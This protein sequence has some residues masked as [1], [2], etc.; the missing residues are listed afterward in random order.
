MKKLVILLIGLFFLG[1]CAA[2]V[3]ED[4]EAIRESGKNSFIT[5]EGST[6]QSA[7]AVAEGLAV[8][9]SIQHEGEI[10][11][12]SEREGTV[13]KIIDGKVERQAVSLEKELSSVSEAGLL[14]FVLTPN[15]SDSQTA[16]AYYTY[17]D[18][19]DP[20]NRIVE[21]N[22]VNDRWQ[23]TKVLL[24]KIP[25]GTH[26][27][28][29]RLA[30]GP[31]D[32]LYATTGDA[33]E[34]EIAQDTASLGGKILRMNLD[35][36]IPEDN[37]FEDSY[38]YSYG[39]RNP[40]GLV[41]DEAGKMYASEH[42]AS[43]NDEINIIEAGKNYGWPTIEGNEEQSGMEAPLFTSGNSTTWAPSGMDYR[44]KTLYVAALRG[45]AVL[46]FDLESNNMR[47]ILTEYGRIRDIYI[48]DETMYFVTNNRDGRGSPQ[49][50]DDKFY[51][52]QLD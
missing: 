1:G 13:A 41:W 48:E 3:S 14:G 9:W 27:H 19:S 42:G 37:P 8:P 40:Q 5:E 2:T 4:E 46:E 23:E 6:N 10:F 30:I 44:D 21:L 39:H 22:L 18:N 34:P 11:Y 35:G 45:N 47:K 36:T 20:L 24:D 31:D 26:H 16:I 51:R 25:S 28:G 52:L 43:S 7:E 49:Q 15:F 29:G 32:R 38:V 50:N 17:E 33:A 12:L